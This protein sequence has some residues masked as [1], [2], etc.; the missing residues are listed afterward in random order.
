M[1]L[2]LSL[3]Y[4]HRRLWMISEALELRMEGGRACHSWYMRIDSHG[5]GRIGGGREGGWRWYACGTTLGGWWNTSRVRD[6][7]PMRPDS[8]AILVRSSGKGLGRISRSSGKALTRDVTRRLRIVA[9]SYGWLR[10]MVLFGC[11][12][13][14]IVWLLALYCCLVVVVVVATTTTT[15]TNVEDDSQ[16]S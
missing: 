2:S 16:K 11:R 13:C 1:L 3:Y 10:S 15:T 9:H 8:T 7:T 5:Y 12:C 6:E 14:N 4:Y